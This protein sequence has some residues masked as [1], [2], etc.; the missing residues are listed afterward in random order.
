MKL[1]VVSN[2]YLLVY[3]SGCITGYF[4][5]EGAALVHEFVG[6]IKALA[7]CKKVVVIHTLQHFFTT[8]MIFSTVLYIGNDFLSNFFE[9]NCCGNLLKCARASRKH[10]NKNIISYIFIIKHLCHRIETNIV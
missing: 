7:H 6:Q 9:Q 8:V 4:I 3:P 5:G 2:E 10:I 1:I